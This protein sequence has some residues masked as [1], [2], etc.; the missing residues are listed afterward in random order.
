M[1]LKRQ[2]EQRMGISLRQCAHPL[3]IRR[4]LYLS[5]CPPKAGL[6]AQGCTVTSPF[7]A[8]KVRW[9]SSFASSSSS[10]R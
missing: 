2:S 8:S 7:T 5:A 3:F 9:F 10:T 1:P 4:G 6:S